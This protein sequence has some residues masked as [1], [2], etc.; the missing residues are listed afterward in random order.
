MLFIV[1]EESWLPSLLRATSA[2]NSSFRPETLA[3]EGG[4]V[5]RK[6]DEMAFHEIGAGVCGIRDYALLL[7]PKRLQPASI[8]TPPSRIAHVEGSGTTPGWVQFVPESECIT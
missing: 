5:G 6:D 3:F 7:R 8:P 4:V 2:F 1:N